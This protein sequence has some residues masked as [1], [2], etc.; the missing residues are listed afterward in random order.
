[1]RS[2]IHLMI[3]FAPLVLYLFNRTKQG[4]SNTKLIIAIA[5]FLIAIIFAA[6]TFFIILI[7][8]FLIFITTEKNLKA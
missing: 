7:S 3:L 6:K 2:L 1:M 5:A 8:A 4:I